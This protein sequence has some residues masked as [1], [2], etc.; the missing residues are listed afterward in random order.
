[1]K[2][3]GTSPDQHDLD[4]ARLVVD[5]LTAEM[6]GQDRLEQIEA[7]IA[8]AL[9]QAAQQ[10]ERRGYNDGYHAG[11]EHV[12]ECVREGERLER[13]RVVAVVDWFIAAADRGRSSSP[14][15]ETHRVIGYHREAYEMVRDRLIDTAGKIEK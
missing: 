13:E 2:D 3:E 4:A 14:D 15:I 5:L 9:R 11:Y 7:R 12:Q 1:M 6:H 8:A 10:A